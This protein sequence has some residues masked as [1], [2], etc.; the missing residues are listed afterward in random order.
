MIPIR[1][2]VR[3]VELGT[4][5]I[6][7]VQATEGMLPRR[8]PGPPSGQNVLTVLSKGLSNSFSLGGP[9]Y[10]RDYVAICDTYLECYLLPRICSLSLCR[11]RGTCGGGGFGWWCEKFVVHFGTSPGGTEV[12]DVCQNGVRW[13]RARQTNMDACATVIYWLI[14]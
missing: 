13:E 12:L 3:L 5:G 6:E 11:A 9:W 7:V 2:L 8:A 14:I 10:S 1:L 4:F